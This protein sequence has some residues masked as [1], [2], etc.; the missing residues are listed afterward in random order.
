MIRRR[1]SSSRSSGARGEHDQG[2]GAH[3]DSG[4]LAVLLQDKV[5]GLEV[6]GEDGWNDAPPIPGT[7]IINVGEI[8]EIASNGYLRANVHRVVSPPAGTD[9]LSIAFF[10]GR[11]ARLRSPAAK[12]SA[13]FRGGGAWADARPTKP[14]L[15]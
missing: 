7:F 9:R 6:E 8:L 2:V 12:P 13:S 14:T 4:F 5:A 1:P 11:A 3:K 15:P 10:L